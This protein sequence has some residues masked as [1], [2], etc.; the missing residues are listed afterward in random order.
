MPK[1]PGNAKPPLTEKSGWVS[2]AEAKFVS[3]ESR[4][5]NRVALHVLLDWSLARATLQQQHGQ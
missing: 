2:G 5:V 3:T 4:M 1:G